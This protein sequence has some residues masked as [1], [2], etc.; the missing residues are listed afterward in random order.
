KL[1]APKT[2][3]IEYSK[4]RTTT[5]CGKVRGQPV[6]SLL[7]AH[8]KLNGCAGQ[9]RGPVIIH[10]LL[11]NASTLQHVTMHVWSLAAPP[12]TSRHPPPI[13]FAPPILMRRGSSRCRSSSR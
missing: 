4:K 13:R 5:C 3:D 11:P 7:T 2:Q 9:G 10:P 12:A 8:Q 6:E 1:G